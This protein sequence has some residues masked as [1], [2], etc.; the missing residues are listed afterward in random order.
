MFLVVSFIKFLS[1]N[2][3]VL[4]DWDSFVNLFSFKSF[5]SLV[6][7]YVYISFVLLFIKVIFVFIGRLLFVIK[8][9]VYP[10]LYDVWSLYVKLYVTVDVEVT[11][12][13]L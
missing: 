3:F 11:F 12:N 5:V 1:L 10:S 9:F 13:L 4:S 2:T 6:T 8:W 7:L